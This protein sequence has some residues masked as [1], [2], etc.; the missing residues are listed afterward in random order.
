VIAQITFQL[1]LR[2][3]GRVPTALFNRAV[4][5]FLGLVSVAMLLRALSGVA[6]HD[7]GL[8]TRALGR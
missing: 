4:L 2:V 5:A 1:G 3:Q 6:P 8:P 7:R